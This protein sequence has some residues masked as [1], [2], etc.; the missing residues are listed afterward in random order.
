MKH[1]M[2]SHVKYMDTDENK[3]YNQSPNQALNKVAPHVTYLSL[4]IVKGTHTGFP[5]FPLYYF[6]GRFQP[7][8]RQVI[9]SKPILILTH[10]FFK[11]VLFYNCNLHLPRLFLC[12]FLRLNNYDN[13]FT[14]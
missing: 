2:G 13:F 9:T 1:V 11:T 8:K 5:L 7:L 14:E 3:G 4:K 6:S 12:L 10:S